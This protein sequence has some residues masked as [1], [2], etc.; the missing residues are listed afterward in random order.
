MRKITLFALSL[1]VGS[2][3]VFAQDEA[4]MEAP[5]EESAPL[6]ISGSI[7][8]Y[9]RTTFNTSDNGGS[10]APNTS[11]ANSTGFAIGMANL[12]VAQE[13]EKAGFVADLVFGPRGDD[14][15]FGSWIDVDGDGDDDTGT[16]S[17]LVNQLYAYLNVTDNLTVTLGNFNTFLGYEVISPTGNFN[18]STSYMFSWGPFSHTGL[19][20]DYAITDELSFMV[21]LMNP[22]DATAFTSVNNMTLGAQLGYSSDA[23]GAWLNFLGGNQS[24]D[25]GLGTYQIDLTTGWDLTDAFYLGFNTTYNFTEG[26]EDVDNAGFLGAALYLQYALSDAFALG[27]RGEYFSEFSDPDAG[28]AYDILGTYDEDGSASVI[29]LTLSANY[30]VGNLTIIPEFRVDLV[31]DT[32]GDP[33]GEAFTDKEGEPTS[34]LASFLVAAVYAF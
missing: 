13:G 6:S 3:S 25:D 34:T 16:N 5:A 17:A 10:A 26:G 20:L 1:M 14:A 18:Y 27:V 23:G 30:T 12:I 21:A 28:N 31:S 22:T 32:G 24:E 11:F 9:Y 7:D 15:V 2:M 19:K 29:D 4:V 33:A 8:T